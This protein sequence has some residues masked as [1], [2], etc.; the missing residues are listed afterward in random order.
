MNTK[1]VDVD[2]KKE[3]KIHFIMYCFLNGVFDVNA[4]GIKQHFKG[5][6][7]PV[8]YMRGLKENVFD[9]LCK[10]CLQDLC[11]LK[12]DANGKITLHT[13][14]LSVAHFKS[15]PEINKPKSL[16]PIMMN[17][18]IDGLWGAPC[19]VKLNDMVLN[20]NNV[21]IPNNHIVCVLSRLNQH[22][23]F[24]NL[25]LKTDLMTPFGTN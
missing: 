20:P 21:V 16:L 18:Y 4:P 19:T 17:E 3:R 12:Y 13:H 25:V 2:Y 10:R 15:K 7:N 9:Q 14:L 8:K 11:K 22:G 23:W 5:I 1:R 24:V 6:D